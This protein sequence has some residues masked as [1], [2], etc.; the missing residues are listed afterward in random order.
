MFTDEE[1]TQKF[2]LLT[3]PQA[4]L[5]RYGIK[6]STKKFRF[7]QTWH[8]LPL[9]RNWAATV[10]AWG[11]IK[12]MEEIQK[13]AGVNYEAMKHFRQRH[14]LSTARNEGSR[15]AAWD[16][17]ITAYQ[18]FDFCGMPLVDKIYHVAGGL[19][20]LPFELY[21]YW[22]EMGEMKKLFKVKN[23]LTLG[24]GVRQELFEKKWAERALAID[25]ASTG[26]YAE[27]RP[28]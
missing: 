14:G 20:I 6:E 8:T 28:R 24:E 26:T 18:D 21:I 19:G 27:A 23:V 22:H 3:A 11:G 4:A 17:A 10:G 25:M 7:E 5:R 12:T 15:R 9:A 1:L 2:N 13:T 16:I